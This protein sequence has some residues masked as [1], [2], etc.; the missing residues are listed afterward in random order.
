[1]ED[2]TPNRYLELQTQISESIRTQQELIQTKNRL[3]D[4]LGRV[5]MQLDFGHTILKVKNSNEFWETTIE[6]LVSSFDQPQAIIYKHNKIKNNLTPIQ[7]FGF[8]QESILPELDINSQFKWREEYANF[9]NKAMQLFFSDLKFTEAYICP[10]FDDTASIDYMIIIG[11]NDEHLR[12]FPSIYNIDYAYLKS[13]CQTAQ[14]MLENQI[15]KIALG[16]KVIERTTELKTSNDQLQKEISERTNVEAALIR[17]TNELKERNKELEQFINVASHDLKSPLRQITSFSSL[18]SQRNHEELDEKSK[19]YL[20]Y[21]ISGSS[22]LYS[23]LEDLLQYSKATGGG[24]EISLIDF[25]E[26]INKVKNSLQSQITKSKASIQLIQEPKIIGNKYQLERVFQNLIENSIK[27]R[28]ECNP[29][30]KID[31]AYEG[32]FC[33]ITVTDNGIGIRPEYSDKVFDIFHR[34]EPKKYDGTG[35]GLA[36]VKKI[37]EKHEG[38]I[39]IDNPEDSGTIINLLLPN[40]NHAL[41]SS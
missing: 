33:H 23:I 20:N 4:E 32:E 30:V 3:D 19:T 35:L 26:I 14:I 17:N 1:M 5:K 12:F 41:L 9:T 37:V 28:S 36:I 34:L 2:T 10:L 25:K 18:L 7:S 24:E 40:H 15:L 29:E 11:A 39:W 22:H 16:K 21:I 38:K 13:F 27:F 6:Y 31:C 8:S